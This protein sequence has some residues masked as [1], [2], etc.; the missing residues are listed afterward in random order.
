MV[1]PPGRTWTLPNRCLFPA[2]A[3]SSVVAC[4]AIACIDATAAVAIALDANA[5]TTL[6]LLSDAT[7]SIEVDATTVITIEI[8]ACLA[9]TILAVATNAATDGSAHATDARIRSNAYRLPATK[10]TPVPLLSLARPSPTRAIPTP[11]P[12]EKA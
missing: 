9:A 2:L 10:T 3:T 4:A 7:A 5:T 11:P 6:T 8:G 1:H 12:K